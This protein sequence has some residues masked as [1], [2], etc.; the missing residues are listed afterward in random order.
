MPAADRLP[1][2]LENLSL[3]VARSPF[4]GWLAEAGEALRALLPRRWRALFEDGAQRLFLQPGAD[5][6]QL[7]ASDRQGDR[8]L[9]AVA[10]D[11]AAD[12]AEIG[13]RLDQ[14]GA[15]RW[16]LLPAS[17]VLRRV[18]SLPAAAEPRLREVLGFEIDRQTPFAAD[19]V[20]FEGRVLG[21]DAGG[22]HLQVELLVLP[23]NSLDA[24]LKAI[25]PLAAGIAGVD[26]VAADGRRLGV[27]L[28][29]AGRR[30]SRSH[31]VRRLNLMLAAAAVFSI[32]LAGWLVLDNRARKLAEF[33]AAVAAANDEARE[34][35]RLR[36]QLQ[37][38]ANA[39]NF[40]A[41]ARAARPTM[42]EVLADL[43]RRI[44]DDTAL[45][46]LAV[47][48]DRLVIVGQSRAAPAL[49]A[50]LQESP[51]LRE[52]ALAGAVQADPR[53][54]RDRFTLTATIVAAPAAAPE[55]E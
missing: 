25:G 32:V 39:A 42:L 14:A 7:F 30:E 13:R 31:P 17:T 19:Q 23:K 10:G 6:I 33:E 47:T 38:S 45:D 46:K 4:P 20:C 43:T 5:G 29:P 36:N 41:N 52:P 50:L 40:L 12:L 16:L 34:A 11:D 18:L 54:G 15:P 44:P 49:V 51:L 21:R 22:Q 35:R 48:G 28:L 9:G 53:S 55:V 3:R 8:H 26:A 37:V 1:A 2:L 27:N 24:A